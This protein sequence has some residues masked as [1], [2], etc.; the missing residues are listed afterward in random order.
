MNKLSKILT[1][2]MLSVLP[3]VANSPVKL[4]K[5]IPLENKL[6]EI[7]KSKTSNKNVCMHKAIRYYLNL[8]EKGE[9]VR[10]VIGWIKGTGYPHAWVEVTNNDKN[11]YLDPAWNI[12]PDGFEKEFYLDRKERYVFEKDA[13]IEDFVLKKNVKKS[14][15]TVDNE[16][17][18]A[19][20]SNKNIKK[21][22]SFN[23]NAELIESIENYCKQDLS[24]WEYYLKN[25]KNK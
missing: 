4:E 24:S 22:K 13:T 3:L 20:N 5:Y 1:V 25:I 11:Y 21:Y 9:D 12:V 19:Y 7:E 2:G 23:T 15:P 6:R 18:K 17:K 10:L 14:F 8:K 16:I